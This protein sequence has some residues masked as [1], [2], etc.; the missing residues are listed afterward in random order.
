[1][2]LD[3]CWLRAKTRIACSGMKPSAPAAIVFAP[4]ANSVVI[5]LFSLISLQIFAW[6]STLAALEAFDHANATQAAVKRQVRQQKLEVNS[7]TMRL[8]CLMC[9]KR[10]LT[11]NFIVQWVT[12]L[13]TP[14]R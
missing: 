11:V 6:C 14:P 12:I 1:M 4:V 5:G 2:N 13:R 3:C 8:G 10:C 9:Q 7:K